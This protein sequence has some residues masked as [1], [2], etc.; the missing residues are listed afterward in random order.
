MGLLAVPVLWRFMGLARL[1][2]VDLSACVAGATLP[3]IANETAKLRGAARR[4]DERA[5]QRRG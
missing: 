4:S 2:F 3:Y 1:D 5:H